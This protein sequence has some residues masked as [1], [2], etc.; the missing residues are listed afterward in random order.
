MENCK[1][2]RRLRYVPNETN[3]LN[4]KQLFSNQKAARNATDGEITRIVEEV[5]EKATTK[6]H[7]TNDKIITKTD[8]LFAR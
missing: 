8:F 6:N 4:S 3:L 5:K 1:K 2:S 7:G